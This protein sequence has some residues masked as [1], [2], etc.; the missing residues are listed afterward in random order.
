VGCEVSA[1][2]PFWRY[3]GG[4]WAAARWYPAPR[5]ETIIEP[6]AGAAGYSCHYPDRRVVLVDQSPVIC[7]I[8]RWLIAV[9]PSEVLAIPD[10]PEGGTV[11]DLPCCQEARWLAGFWCNQ[12]AAS[13]RKRP[14][15][16]VRSPHPK[17][18]NTD[19][20]GWRPKVRERIA[21]QVPLIRHWQ[22]IE[23]DYREAPDVEATWHVDPPYQV[24]GKYYPYRLARDDYAALGAWCLSLRGQ[25]MVCEQAGADWLP[26]VTMAEVHAM[27]GKQKGS[28]TTSSEVVWPGEGTQ[29]RL[30]G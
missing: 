24:A 22:V 21:R 5:Y 29:T 6:F 3:Y 18:G 8:W 19:T 4:K 20:L 28:R 7:G 30:F 10:I 14:S 17:V 9:E 25:V 12:G 16:W 27:S 13:P 15:A 1:L 23:G 26:F 11:D 2:R